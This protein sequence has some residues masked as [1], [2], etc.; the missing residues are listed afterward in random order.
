MRQGW[1]R[2]RGD[3]AATEA[4]VE[5]WRQGLSRDEGELGGQPPNQRSSSRPGSSAPALHP[6][7]HPHS[8]R[9]HRLQLVADLGLRGGTLPCERWGG[10]C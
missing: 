6:P 8:V 2:R 3:R 10:L 1:D 5:D 9:Q 7:A 4:G